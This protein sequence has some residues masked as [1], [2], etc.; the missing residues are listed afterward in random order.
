MRVAPVGTV[1]YEN[2][3]RAFEIGVETAAITHSHPSGY[4]SAGCLAAILAFLAQGF[5]LVNAIIETMGLLVRWQDNQE[6]VLAVQSTL[7]KYQTLAPAPEN[8]ETLV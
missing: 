3:E 5:S 4:L 8:V 7:D 2:P 6:C 1:F